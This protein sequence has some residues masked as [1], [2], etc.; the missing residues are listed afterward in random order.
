ML[1]DDFGLVVILN[2]MTKRA[3]TTPKAA[4]KRVIGYCRVS[5]SQQASEGVSLDAQKALLASYAAAYGLEVVE[6][7]VDAGE[8]AK[9]L[10]RP[11]LQRALTMLANGE[12]DGLLVTK[13]DRLTR[14]LRDLG[15][16]LAGPF[17]PGRRGL[18]SVSEHLDTE[19]AA[20]R[21][22]LNILT[23]VAQWER[24]AVC[25]RT[26]AV[27]IYQKAKGSFLGGRV[28][29]GFALDAQGA[30]FPVDAEQGTIARARELDATGL[31]LGKISKTL[32]SEGR[33]ARN[34]RAFFPQQ[35]A[36]MLR[37]ENESAA[38]A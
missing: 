7:I 33:L 18:I 34:G 12:A 3:K 1:L 9:S 6:V 14:S 13:L 31:S 36:N 5:T 8:S 17:A 26:A 30:L 37:D 38:A 28:P 22:L 10:Q 35:I 4:V 11:G 32:A 20:G 15:D 27:K 2:I 19:S 25:E 23:S 16:L 21:L 24:E 29:Y